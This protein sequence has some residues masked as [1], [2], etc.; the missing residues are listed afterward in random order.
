MGCELDALAVGNLY[1]EKQ[2]QNLSLK[3]DYK[4]AF[5]PD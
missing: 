5:E 1:L 4:N 3:L 2:S